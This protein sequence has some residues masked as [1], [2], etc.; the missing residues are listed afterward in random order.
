MV[1]RLELTG[2]D[3]IRTRYSG[4]NILDHS[5]CQSPCHTFNLELRGARG[6]LLV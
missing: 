3:R 2:Y 6:G 1:G 5:L 4:Y